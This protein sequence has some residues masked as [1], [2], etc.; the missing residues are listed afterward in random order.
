AA[1][2][3]SRRGREEY[4]PFRAAWL[5]DNATTDRG[6]KLEPREQMELEHRR[7]EFARYARLDMY[8][9]SEI[10]YNQH[11]REPSTF[12]GAFGRNMEGYQDGWDY[13]TSEW[14]A[15]NVGDLVPEGLR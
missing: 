3:Q 7:R 5:P 4:S 8:H 14:L 13:D 6:P 1:R 2:L 12:W 15:L 9:P 10:I 11:L